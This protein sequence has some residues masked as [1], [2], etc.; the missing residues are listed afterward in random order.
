MSAEWD[1]T[2]CDRQHNSIDKSIRTIEN[3]VEI[4]YL[5]TSKKLDAINDY[6]RGNVSARGLMQRVDSIEM[7]V[8]GIEDFDMKDRLDQLS[9]RV[10]DIYS[11]MTE[12]Q[13]D[14]LKKEQDKSD[15]IKRIKESIA[16][17]LGKGLI[18]ILCFALLKLLM[19]MWPVIADK[20][21]LLIDILIK[22][23]KD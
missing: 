21:Q 13:N 7:A 2:W 4:D 5:K 18:F 8:K 1:P 3:K 10:D 16:S 23:I 6:I 9:K 17:W 22:T 11:V 20:A 12:C 19:Y 15:L 14:K